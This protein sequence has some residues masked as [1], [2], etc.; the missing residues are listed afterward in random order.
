MDDDL[1]QNL[2]AGE[3]WVRGLFILMFVFM[4]VVARLVTGAVVVIQF[5]F[6]VFTGQINDN[7]KT[8]GASLA[9]YVYNCLLFVTYNSDDKPFPF[10][11]WPAAEDSLAEV[12]SALVKAKP[13]AKP[14]S[15][16]KPKAKPKA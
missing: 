3:T 7:L 9:R 12:E 4:L 2:T 6:T 8:F 14:K 5:L 13:A 1:K 10:G 15:K 16:A 11:E